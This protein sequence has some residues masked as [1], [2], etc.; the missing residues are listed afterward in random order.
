MTTIQDLTRYITDKTHFVSLQE[1]KDFACAFLDFVD[2]G[3]HTVIKCENEWDYD[4]FQ[5]G[6]DCRYNVSRPINCKLFG[7]I[8]SFEGQLEKFDFVMGEIAS[9]KKPAKEY[10][11][12]FRSTIYTLQQSIG[13]ALDALPASSANQAKKI[14]GDLF[15]RLVRLLMKQV[16][17]DCKA[18]VL[19]IPVKDEDGTAM[20]TEVFQHDLIGRKNGK[21]VFIG[22]VKTSSKD[23]IDKIFVDKL[24]FSRLSDYNVPYIAVFLNDV[25]RAKGTAINKFK[26]NSTFL[27][28]H[29]KAY[30]LGLSPIDGVY[31]CDLRPNM[32]TDAF[33]SRHIFG[34]D[35]LFFDELK[36]YVK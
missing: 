16:R 32:M 9:K 17:V 10:R 20:T 35:R 2:K 4:F 13:A 18:G 31:Y 24:M 5:Y 3:L 26:V 6:E 27:S 19:Q 21:V 23:R 8:A 11:D 12:T 33:L 22:S 34:I 30:T 15:E 28:G 29:F 25:Q 36:P 14:N 1:Y 7:N